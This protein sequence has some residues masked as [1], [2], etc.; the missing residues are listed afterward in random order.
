MTTKQRKPRKHSHGQ[1]SHRRIPGTA[2][3]VQ[4]CSC[5]AERVSGRGENEYW[6]GPWLTAEEREKERLRMVTS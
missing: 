1:M 5:G 6:D 4:V 3:A 2:M